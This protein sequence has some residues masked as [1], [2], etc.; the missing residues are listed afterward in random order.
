MYRLFR[1]AI[2]GLD[3]LQIFCQYTGTIYNTKQIIYMYDLD[4]SV[5]C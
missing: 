3:D 4:G 2:D 1:P 5:N